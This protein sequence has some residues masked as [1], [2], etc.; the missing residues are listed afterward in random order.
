MIE[1]VAILLVLLIRRH[2]RLNEQ[3][4]RFGLVVADRLK[5]R[6]GRE[7][8]AH[9][10]ERALERRRVGLAAASAA[11]VTVVS[12]S[13][14]SVAMPPLTIAALID[15]V[16]EP[17]LAKHLRLELGTDAMLAER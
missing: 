2:A 14:S 8:V 7:L 3:L 13:G 16:E 4:H 12:T 11:G 17:G 10:P 5:E 6:V 9:L 1:R 15:G